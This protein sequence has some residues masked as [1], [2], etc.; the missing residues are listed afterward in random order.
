MS[1][2]QDEMDKADAEQRSTDTDT[3][4]TLKSDAININ[5]QIT[6]WHTRGQD[7]ATAS[8]NNPGDTTDLNALRAQFQSIADASLAKLF[9]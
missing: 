6:A 5:N 8:T 4:G 9:T 1:Y 2:E 7:L 3:Y